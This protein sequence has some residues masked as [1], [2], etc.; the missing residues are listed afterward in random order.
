L[1]HLIL[2]V[3][4][5]YSLFNKGMGGRE[6]QR[7]VLNVIETAKV[8]ATGD[9]H[10]EYKQGKGMMSAEV[11]NEIKKGIIADNEQIDISNFT[12]GMYFLKFKNGNTIK[13][14]KE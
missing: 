5:F 14:I 3:K 8:K 9:R 13:F 7:L 6:A 1:I 11:E 2:N 10:S 12:N 4:V